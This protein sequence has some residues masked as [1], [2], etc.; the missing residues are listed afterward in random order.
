M[1]QGHDLSA[2]LDIRSGDVVSLVG[3]GG[4]TTTMYRLCH[5]LVARGLRVIST[6][7][8]AIQRPTVRQSRQLLLLDE[9]SDFVPPVRAAL[10]R[11]GH[12]SVA[13]SAR[14]VDK[15]E[16]LDFERISEL[17]GLANVV[18][19]EADGAR[20]A[21]IK[22]PADH[23]PAVPGYTTAFLSVAG[24][25]SLGRPLAEV[26]HRPQLAAQLC[27][28]EDDAPVTPHTMACLL[29][30]GQGGLK[31]RPKG[32]R[33]WA[34]LTHLSEAN[35]QEAREVAAGVADAPYNGAVAL[36]RTSVIRLA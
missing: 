36:S 22:A 12:I 4:K 14:R 32:A 34:L 26:C 1:N 24:L 11:H 30:S 35:E 17:A 28:Q 25:H 8:T 3:A 7:T 27:S 29:G 13:G 16:G 5:E 23:E 21:R 6:T 15:V 2:V 33:A 19:I 18:V 31:G 10:E 20:H 9:I